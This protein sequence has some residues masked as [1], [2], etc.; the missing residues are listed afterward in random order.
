MRAAPQ[1]PGGEEEEAHGRGEVRPRPR[2]APL[3]RFGGPDSS[4]GKDLC[5]AHGKM[6][7]GRHACKQCKGE[8]GR[9]GAWHLYEEEFDV[10]PWDLERWLEK[11]PKENDSPQKVPPP[12][13]VE[14]KSAALSGA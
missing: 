8:R 12:Q 6:P 13:L 14:R 10:A 2:E 3:P 11:E 5:V 4:C 7:K 9:H 1:Q